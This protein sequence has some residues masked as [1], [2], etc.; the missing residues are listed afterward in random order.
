MKSSIR[1]IVLLVVFNNLVAGGLGLGAKS[2]EEK[3]PETQPSSG[4]SVTIPKQPEVLEKDT[5]YTGSHRVQPEGGLCYVVRPE[6]FRDGERLYTDRDYMLVGVPEKYRGLTY[7]RT[8]QNDKGCTRNFGLALEVNTAVI[9]YVARDDRLKASPMWLQAFD[10]TGDDVTSNDAFQPTYSIYAKPFPKGRVILGPNC[11]SMYSCM[12]LVALKE[13]RPPYA[14]PIVLAAGDKL[15]GEAPARVEFRCSVLCGDRTVEK[16][17]WDFGDEA[18]KSSEGQPVH[19]YTAEGSYVATVSVTDSNGQV[20]SARVGI[21]V[22]PAVASTYEAAFSGLYRELGKNYPC[23]EL[24]GIDWEKVGEEML[25]RARDA[26][27]NEEFGLLCME[28]VARLQDSHAY[29]MNGSAEV[30]AVAFPRWDA[31]FACLIDDRGRPVVYYVDK[32]GSAETAAVTVGMTVLSI[33]G[34]SADSHMENLMRRIKKY[35]GYSSERYLRYHAAQWLGRQMDKGSE[36]DVQMQHVDGAIRTFKLSADLGVR[37]LPRRPMQIPGTS[38]TAN[39]SWTKLEDDIGYIY[40]RRIR[41]DLIRRLDEAVRALKT[42]RGLIVDVR[43]NSGGGFDSQRSHRNFAP[44]DKQEPDR[45]RFQGPIA[46]LTDARCISA[47]E[48]WASWF[49]AEKRAR[50]F[51]EATAGASSRKAVY[52]LTNGLFKAQ[53]PVKAY[54]GYLQRPIERRGLEPDVPIRQNARDLAAGRD[55]VLQ[56]AKRY[57]IKQAFGPGS[58][59]L[60]TPVEMT[61]EAS[62]QLAVEASVE[63]T[64]RRALRPYQPKL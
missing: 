38:D 6:A 27:T 63:M 15:E 3:A 44:D 33:D 50:V 58:S 49:I 8:C 35:S 37:Y 17:S 1:K 25:P 61:V 4:L 51:G 16:Y 42:T 18:E 5:R 54:K 43:G 24:K 28:L 21:Q 23:F 30:P 9:A 46:L 19:I 60:S 31:G 29:L 62:S 40:V 36:M 39:V 26:K 13:L 57:L 41:E 47:G 11:G 10:D 45:P 53:Y 14:E 22:H 52:A 59:D 32:G 48:G 64:V 34:E 20:H 56:A 12:Y 2:A 55:A 7:V